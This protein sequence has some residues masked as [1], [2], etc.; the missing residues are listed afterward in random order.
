MAPETGGIKFDV[1]GL[2]ILTSSWTDIQNGL[3]PLIE[4]DDESTYSKVSS[5]N[6]DR[7]TDSVIDIS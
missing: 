3:F 1:P 2:D 4:L 6:L 5:S 7:S